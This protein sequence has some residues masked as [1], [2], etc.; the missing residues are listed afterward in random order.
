MGALLIWSCFGIAAL[1]ILATE[2]RGATLGLVGGFELWRLVERGKS[3]WFLLL[4][5]RTG[6]WSAS[7]CLDVLP[8][9]F[10]VPC[11]SCG[12][13]PRDVAGGGVEAGLC[14]LISG[15][16]DENRYLSRQFRMSGVAVWTKG[17]LAASP[18]VKRSLIGL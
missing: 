14:S 15:Y 2:P 13:C 6:V 5:V 18:I 16:C 10:G 7:P 1:I 17:H 3:P 12:G 11:C 8:R 4:V 9:S